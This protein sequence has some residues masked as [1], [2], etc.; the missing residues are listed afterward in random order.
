VGHSLLLCLR[1]K[2]LYLYVRVLNTRLQAHSGSLALYLPMPSALGIGLQAHCANAVGH[3]LCSVCICPRHWTPSPQRATCSVLSAYA[4]ST[5]L[6]SHNG[7]PALFCLFVPSALDCKLTTGHLF[8]SI[9]PCPLRGH[10]LQ[11]HCGSLALCPIVS[12]MSMPFTGHRLQEHCGSL[13]LFYLI[14]L[15]PLRERKLQV[16]YGPLVLFHLS[17]L[18]TGAQATSPLRATCSGCAICTSSLYQL[19]AICTGCR[20]YK[21]VCTEITPPCGFALTEKSKCVASSL[22]C[23]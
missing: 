9:C 6:Q 22:E 15:H 3:L 5:R 2:P 1:H 12:H 20:V 13:A 16:H 19:C 14:C 4:L 11:V 17:M 10:R 18:F 8:C 7:S 23:R 21:S